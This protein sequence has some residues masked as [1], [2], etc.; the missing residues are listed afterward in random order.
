MWDAL[1]LGTHFLTLSA[2]MQTGEDEKIEGPAL[3]GTLAFSLLLGMGIFVVFP[4][5]LGSGIESWLKLDL[6]WVNIIEGLIRLTVAIGYIWLIGRMPEISR[7]FSYHGAEH[8]TINAYEAG[9]EL[10]PE[11]VKAFSLEH[12]RCGTGFLLTVVIFSILVFSP[13]RP[14]MFWVR[15]PLQLVLVPVIACFAYEYMRWTAN[16]LEYRWVRR[17]IWPN[18]ALQHLTTREPSLEMLEVSIA[19]FNAMITAERSTIEETETKSSPTRQRISMKAWQNILLGT[20]LGL[21]ASAII[22]LIAAQPRGE[23]VILPPLPTPSQ[24]IVQV[25]GAVLNPGLVTLPRQSRVMNAIEAAGGFLANADQES[26]NLAAR[27]NDGDRILVQDQ[28]ARATQQEA[29]AN[30]DPKGRNGTVTPAPQYPININTATQPELENLPNIGPAK[31]EAIIAF[32][33]QQGRFKKIEDIQ[34]VTGIGPTIFDRIKD[35]ITVDD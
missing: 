26:L 9:A 23:S 30:L 31:A 3:Y 28:S 6:L 20:F 10:R 33:Q 14:L 22:L 32:R 5:A 27:I 24:I 8:K 13:L 4:S 21:A 15:V 18:L 11:V 1:I 12:P 29:A 2:N 19:S 25:G 7:V 17:L 34:N 16:H 35:L